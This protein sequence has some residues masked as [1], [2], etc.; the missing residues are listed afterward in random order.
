VTWVK[1]NLISICLDMVL[2]LVQDGARF[3][4]KRTIWS[5]IVLQAPYGTPR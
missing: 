3:C 5:E 2:A 1:S 4:V